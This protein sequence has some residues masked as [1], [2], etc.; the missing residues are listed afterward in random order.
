MKA[1]IVYFGFDRAAR[2]DKPLL[3]G[4]VAGQRV[5]VYG[6]CVARSVAFD[7]SWKTRLTD[8]FK[9]LADGAR[10]DLILRREDD[11]AA[12]YDCPAV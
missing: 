6:P 3:T 5:L 11:V 12:V 10:H 7:A 2:G 4:Y 1:E 9:R 8:Q